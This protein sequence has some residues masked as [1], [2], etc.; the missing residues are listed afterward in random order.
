MK[1]LVLV[2]TPSKNAA[3]LRVRKEG[4]QSNIALGSCCLVRKS[5]WSHL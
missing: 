2:V 5:S 1:I 4:V 3:T